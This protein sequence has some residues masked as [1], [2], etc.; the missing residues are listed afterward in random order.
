MEIMIRH[1]FPFN[2][3]VLFM[4]VKESIRKHPLLFALLISMFFLALTPI[5][6]YGRVSMLMFMPI[7][8]ITPLFFDYLSFKYNK[9]WLLILVMAVIVFYQFN[10]QTFENYQ[11]RGDNPDDV[12]AWKYIAENIEEPIYAVSEK[13]DLMLEYL[14]KEDVIPVNFWTLYGK[15]WDY[16]RPPDDP[17]SALFLGTNGD[18][19][20]VLNGVEKPVWIYYNYADGYWNER[21]KLLMKIKEKS[22]FDV[23]MTWGN[24]VLARIV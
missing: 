2:I 19:Y 14:G 5:N 3:L 23:N 10:M 4:V 13:D 9:L 22:I 17:L 12:R 7:A 15:N 24:A 8:F 18:V 11:Y 16:G 21:M 1:T 20:D 6:G